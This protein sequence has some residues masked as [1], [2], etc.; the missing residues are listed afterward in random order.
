MDEYYYYR[1]KH[2]GNKITYRC[3]M[4]WKALGCMKKYLLRGM[5][6]S[7]M[8]DSVESKYQFVM[9]VTVGRE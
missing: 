7:A 8:I 4:P 5:S 1:E 3:A 6:V 9:K 2:H